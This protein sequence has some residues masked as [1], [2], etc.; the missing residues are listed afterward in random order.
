MPGHP[1]GGVPSDHGDRGLRLRVVPILRGH[2]RRPGH[3]RAYPVQA[4]CCSV[5]A[6][7]WALTTTNPQLYL[8]HLTATVEQLDAARSILREVVALAADA[9]QL[10][11][12]E[13]RDRLLTLAFGAR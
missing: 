9:P 4:W 5:C 11:D 13:I 10:A 8:D 7:Q 3:A 1:A 2:Y 6:T 12:V